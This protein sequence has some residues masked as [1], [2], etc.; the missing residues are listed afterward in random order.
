[1]PPRIAKERSIAQTF[2]DGRYP[3]LSL[4]AVSECN[5]ARSNIEWLLR[6]SSDPMMSASDGSNTIVGMH[7]AY[8][9]SGLLGALA[10]SVS[11]RILLITDIVKST[12]DTRSR[13]ASPGRTYLNS[14]LSSA[15]AGYSIASFNAPGL[16]LSLHRDM[17]LRCACVLDLLGLD[18]RRDIVQTVKLALGTESEL[19]DEL[20]LRRMFQDDFYDRDQQV[21]LGQKAWLAHIIGSSEIIKLELAAISAIDS[22]VFSKN[23]LDLLAQDIQGLIVYDLA[24]PDSESMQTPAGASYSGD[25]YSFVQDNYN[26]RLRKSPQQVYKATVRGNVTFMGTLSDVGGKRA[27]L[28]IPNL[29]GLVDPKIESITMLGKA[30][31]SNAERVD[32]LTILKC[33]QRKIPLLSD[34][35]MDRLFPPAVL[36]ETQE[37]PPDDCHAQ[38]SPRA[39]SEWSWAGNDMSASFGDQPGAR[40]DLGTTG[41]S[42]SA[43]YMMGEELDG[44][45]LS[46]SLAP[47]MT[48]PL[49]CTNDGASNDWATF[50]PGDDPWATMPSKNNIMNYPS[51]SVQ[52]V[53]HIPYDGVLN[54]SQL[55]AVQDMLDA[56]KFVS[57]IKGPPGTGKTT[58]IAAYVSSIL[59]QPKKTAWITAQTNVAAKNIAEKFLSAGISDWVLLVSAEF[60]E[61]W[62]E[63]LY[64]KIPQANILTSAN[65][66]TAPICKIVICTMSMLSNNRV[67]A[68]S[69][70]IPLQYLVVDEASQIPMTKYLPI[71]SRFGKKLKKFCFI[72]DDKQL[73][74]FASDTSDALDSVFENKAL[75]ASVQ[76]L[77]MNI[78]YRMPPAIGQFISTH[79]YS[80]ELHSW[81]DH[82]VHDALCCQ[83]INVKD[84]RE[85]SEGKTS[86]KNLIE[87]SA[88]L[89]IARMLVARQKPFKVITPYDAQRTLLENSLKENGLPWANTCFTV[90]SF[91]GNEEDFIIISIVRTISGKE[92][93]VYLL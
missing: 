93:N 14:L 22:T 19:Y 79:V 87:I 71:I 26:R 51:V 88:V 29:D 90:D 81:P 9:K 76:V 61:G 43:N 1:M 50:L 6:S 20:S 49:E 56:T 8:T 85:E 27:T 69:K 57:I 77:L 54:P 84:G 5:C 86:F 12:G 40:I 82:P 70:S 80:N 58:I 46:V 21:D 45:P 10:L 7:A 25:K 78:Q 13:S 63:H 3:P 2:I 30:G 37:Y 42:L 89:K 17:S 18:P 62:H 52:Q 53:Q 75:V 65:F 73:P 44:S 33:L 66:K 41:L 47:A 24:K 55:L 39:D 67:L 15:S 91:Q 4:I 60:L 32:F 36:V 59:S 64:E 72:G 11:P 16:V 83:F 48:S 23:E 74:P 38:V 31:P 35:W 92:G 28:N 68:F 34:V